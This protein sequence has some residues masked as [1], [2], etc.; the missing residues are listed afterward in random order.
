VDYRTGKRAGDT[1]NVLDPSD[2]ELPQLVQ[3]ACLR[4]GD[5]VVGTG[6]PSA[7]VTPLT[8]ATSAATEP[9]TP[10][11]VWMRMYAAIMLSS[12]AASDERPGHHPTGSRLAQR[13]RLHEQPY[14]LKGAKTPIGLLTRDFGEGI[15]E[16]ILTRR[17]GPVSCFST[18]CG[19]I[20]PI[21]HLGE[22]GGI[23]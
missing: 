9:T 13:K 19:H 15:P 14:S 20:G 12:Q 7:D 22:A 5:H 18:F 17:P 16:G 10:T 2:H 3:V 21:A 4:P 23:P 1:W 6:C 11:S 8:P